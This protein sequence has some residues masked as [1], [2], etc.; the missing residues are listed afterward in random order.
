[1]ANAPP[2]TT[3]TPWVLPP[4]GGY[5]DYQL[6][7]DYPPAVEIAVVAR[8]W[9]AGEPSVGLYNICYVNAFQTQPPDGSD[10][11]DQRSGWPAA[12]VSSFEDPEWPGEFIIDLGTDEQRSLAAAFVDTMVDTCAE[13]GFD[14]V[15]FDNLDTYTRAADVPFGQA[16]ALAFAAHIAAH[17]HSLGLAVGQKNTSELTREQAIDQVSFDFAVVEECAEYNECMAYRSIYGFAVLALEYSVA[18]MTKACTDFGVGVPV[19]RRDRN[20][21]T[22]ADPGYEFETFCGFRGYG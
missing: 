15:E 3:L 10:R 12:V 1:M 11:P 14:A 19:L 4:R 18:G 20:L 2:P 22:P 16:E 13:K 8:D 5:F 9:F 21:V 7:G 17:A 6:G